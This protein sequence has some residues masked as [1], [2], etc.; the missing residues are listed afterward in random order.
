M[1]WHFN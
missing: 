1:Y